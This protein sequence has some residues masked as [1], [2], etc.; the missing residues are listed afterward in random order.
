M[1]FYAT[2]QEIIEFMTQNRQK[3]AGFTLVELVIVIA[4]IA[5]LVA[6][7]LPS[8]ENS[9]RKARRSAAQSELLGFANTAERFF[10][11]EATYANAPLPSGDADVFKYYTFSFAAGPS[12]TGYTIQATPKSGTPQAEDGCGTMR[13]T[14]TGVKTATGTE[15][16]C[17][18][19]SSG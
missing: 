2:G 16:N 4:V 17:W 3:R 19:S 7:A 14:N 1:V 13:L 6:I 5:L 11:E 10:T 18:G 8:Y 9:V 12:A 15:S